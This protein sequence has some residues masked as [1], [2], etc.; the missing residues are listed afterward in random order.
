[1]NGFADLQ[2]I[3]ESF[4]DK[5]LVSALERGKRYIKTTYPTHCSEDSDIASHNI[6]FALSDPKKNELQAEHENPDEVCEDCFQLC[7]SMSDV[8]KLA[9]KFEA[10]EDIMYDI[11][12]A[13]KSVQEYIC[14][15]LRDVQQRKAKEWCME[16][17]DDETA[18]W[19]KDFCQKILPTQFRE[20]QQNYF[21]KKGMSLHV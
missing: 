1:M 13:I 7:K 19:L 21:G 14:H 11:N 16:N 18:F 9:E 2:K 10:D 3:A 12:V 15:I 4:G 6:N 20:G 8:R 17:L 5:D